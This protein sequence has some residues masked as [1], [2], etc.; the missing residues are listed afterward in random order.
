[1]FESVDG[2]DGDV[3]LSMATMVFLT[4]VLMTKCTVDVRMCSIDEATVE[5]CEC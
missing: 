3:Y 4:V 5:L 2:D 1:M